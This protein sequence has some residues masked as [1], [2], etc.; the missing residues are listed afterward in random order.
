MSQSQVTVQ[1][2]EYTVFTVNH[3]YFKVLECSWQDHT[4]VEE[5]A[6]THMKLV[7][8][9]HRTLL[10]ESTLSECLMI[11]LEGSSIDNFNPDA[12]IN[13]WFD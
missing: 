10:N 9:D 6:F 1:P 5:R 4:M 8:S 11:K 7:K 12:V 2:P 3:G 13:L